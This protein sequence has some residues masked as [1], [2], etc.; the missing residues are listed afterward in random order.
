[1]TAITGVHQYE[2]RFRPVELDSATALEAVRF[3]TEG[4]TESILGEITEITEDCEDT[5]TVLK[6]LR[7][8][9]QRIFQRF[10]SIPEL[11]I[12]RLSRFLSRNKARSSTRVQRKRAS[13]TWE[14]SNRIYK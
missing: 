12:R 13:T 3:S 7:R 6:L 5:D 9:V 10:L 14:H 4:I 8:I 1:M 2:S 11:K